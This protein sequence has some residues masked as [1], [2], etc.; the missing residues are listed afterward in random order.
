MAWTSEY[1][2]NRPAVVVVDSGIVD[3]PGTRPT[4]DEWLFRQSSV[5]GESSIGS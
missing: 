2:D 3:A 1:E 5:I 4:G